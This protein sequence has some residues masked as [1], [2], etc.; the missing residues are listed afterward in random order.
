[1]DIG[2]EKGVIDHHLDNI[3]AYIKQLEI[4]NHNLL[5]SEANLESENWKLRQDIELYQK[6]VQDYKQQ[7]KKADD[8]IQKHADLLGVFMMEY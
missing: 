6:M 8:F 3:S 2:F 7:L 4:T 1:M 5:S